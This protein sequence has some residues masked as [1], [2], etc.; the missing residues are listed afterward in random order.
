MTSHLVKTLD[1]ISAPCAGVSLGVIVFA[2]L[3]IS[4]FTDM[5][6]V[7]SFTWS[8]RSGEVHDNLEFPQPRAWG[9]VGR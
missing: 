9:V 1:L 3:D 5:L 8:M 4:S 6:D 2:V 7:L